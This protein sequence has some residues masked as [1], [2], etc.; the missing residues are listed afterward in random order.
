MTKFEVEYGGENSEGMKFKDKLTVEGWA[1]AM[2]NFL[3]VVEFMLTWNY[4]GY[5]KVLML[6]ENDGQTIR[7]AIREC[8]T[9]MT[10]TYIL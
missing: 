10:N 6:T 4:G 2:M 8:R 9:M 7:T 3:G 1:E 5:V